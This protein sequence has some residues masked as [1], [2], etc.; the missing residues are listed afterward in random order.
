VKR[1]L[2]SL[3]PWTREDIV[4]VLARA[5]RLKSGAEHGQPLQGRS[6][7]LIFEQE[8][9]RTRVSFEV[10][11]AQLGGH[12]IFLH[13]GDIGI[14]TRESVHDIATVLGRYND[15][16]V[17]R[18]VRHQTLVQ[19]AESAPVPV[20]NAMTDLVHPC[21]ILS[22]AFTLQER[23]LLV[24]E[25]RIAF[26]GDGGTMLNSLLELAEKI[27]LQIAAAVP[28]GHEPHPQLLDQVRASG[29]SSVEILHKP[30]QAVEGARVVMADP[31]P[32]LHGEESER[33]SL[34]RPFQVNARLLRGAHPEVLI[35]H[36]LPA[37]RGEEITR[38]VLD[39]KHSIVLGQ[40]ENRLHVQKAILL[41]LL[42]LPVSRSHQGP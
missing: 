3:T 23:E 7:A 33:H 6:A 15:V 12:P 39:G 2:I 40:A 13:Q 31:W 9:L 36:R 4:A 8:S 42:A 19:F 14:A 17:A 1:D 22:D 24:P 27:P 29:C 28:P 38:E 26:C 41:Y 11:I 18:T 5:G 16:I 10:G 21:Q 25:T 35:M 34:F 32:D 20:I 37:R 30:E